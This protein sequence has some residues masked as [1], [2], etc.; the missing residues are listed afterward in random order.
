MSTAKI[1]LPITGDKKYQVR[2]RAALPLLVRQAQAGCCVS[3]S[4]L[5][6]ELVM[7][8]RNLNYV[9]GSIGR[10][11]ESLSVS[12]KT[13]IPPIQCLVVN[14]KT[15]LPGA[16][17]GEFLVNVKEKN[18]ATLTPRE[19]RA[20]VQAALQKVFSYHRWE[21][22]LKIL[23]L[24]PMKFDFTSIVEKASGGFGGG[25]SDAH[26]ALKEYVAKNPGVIGLSSTTQDGVTECPLPSG[27]SLDVSFYDEE[28]WVAV[29][30]KSAKSNENDIVRGLFQCVKYQA[31][32]EAVL[33]SKA[34]SIIP[35][36]YLVLGS[37]FPNSL[38]PLRNILGVEVVE[39][40]TPIG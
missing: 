18:F 24:E 32:M 15:R 33:L 5:A 2:A 37:V 3:Y 19:K 28:G 38:I 16:G 20:I 14:K 10:S 7:R 29:E 39:K 30:V 21:E 11:L 8:P 34:S 6:E 22:V 40:I 4:D 26:K 27:D 17:I 12:R 31:V 36:V 23:E 13:E 35:K 1:A 9:L 25:E